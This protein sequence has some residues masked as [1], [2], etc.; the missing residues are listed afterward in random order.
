MKCLRCQNEMKQYNL[1]SPI[2][3][4]GKSHKPT[5]YSEET[6]KSHNIHSAF[7]CDNCGY[8]ELSTKVCESPNN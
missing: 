4:F 6:E 2:T 1:Y 7:I 5:L 3:I 8:S